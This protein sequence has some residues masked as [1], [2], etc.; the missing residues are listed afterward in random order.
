MT[1]LP[2]LSDTLQKHADVWK[3]VGQRNMAVNIMLSIGT[4]LLLAVDKQILEPS[5]I[6]FHLSH[7]IVV[8]QNYEGNVDFDSAKHQ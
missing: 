7:G 6:A 1:I 2:N 8:L 5:N 3:N 4:N